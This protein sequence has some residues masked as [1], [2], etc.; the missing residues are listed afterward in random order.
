MLQPKTRG[1]DTPAP[2]ARSSRPRND[3]PPF[4][5]VLDAVLV[6]DYGD[7]NFEGA[8]RRHEAQAVWTWFYRDVAPDLIDPEA[9]ADA[10]TGAAVEAIVPV[11]LSRARHLSTAASS[12]L[13]AQRRLRAQLGGG[14]IFH[15][16]P[17]VLNALKCVP[18]YEKARAFGRAI[19]GLPDDDAVMA[20]LQS[21]PRQDSATSAVLMMA[22]VREIAAPA[23]LIV[24]ATRIAGGTS[25]TDLVRAG[26][27]PL[28]DACLAQ[29]QATIPPLL[30]TGAFA[31]LDLVCR[32]IERF[33]RLVRGISANV[34]LLP[35]GGRWLGMIGA[36]TKAMSERLE[37]R[38]RDIPLDI[39]RGLRRQREG[40]DRLDSDALLAALNGAYLLATV[41]DCRDSLAVNEVFDETWNRAGQT[42]E[43]HLTRNLESLRDDPGNAMFAARVEGGIKIAELRFGTDYA[44][45][46]RKA[47][48]AFDRRFG[49][50]AT[51]VGQRRS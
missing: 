22:A 17:A 46:L 14:E 9:P 32:S 26:F 35:R 31:D 21:M 18:L 15:R 48:D 38:L 12:N 42:L 2:V 33:H 28:L 19:N 30:Q 4:L 40:S 29:A 37:P 7:F 49:A 8:I 44:D 51:P 20:A 16:L 10:A 6:D 39:N 47:R 43:L 24:P 25:E 13:E 36:L 50:A 34:D 5:G 23:R 11:L 27:A 1:P 41:R 45:V 3:R